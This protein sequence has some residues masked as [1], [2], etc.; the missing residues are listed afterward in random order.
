MP[1]VETGSITCKMIK[2]LGGAT[3]I[4][5]I[6]IGMEKP[7]QIMQMTSGV[8]EILNLAIVVASS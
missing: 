6:L 2:E 1:N 8:S 4:G 5:P 3:V 7:V